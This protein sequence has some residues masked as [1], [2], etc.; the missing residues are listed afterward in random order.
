MALPV[1]PV[2]DESISRYYSTSKPYCPVYDYAILDEKGMKI[3]Y[4]DD[5]S[6]QNDTLILDYDNGPRPNELISLSLPED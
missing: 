6:H 3:D 5:M 2:V 1:I 4:V